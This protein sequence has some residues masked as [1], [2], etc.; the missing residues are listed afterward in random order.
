MMNKFIEIA[1]VRERLDFAA[2]FEAVIIGLHEIRYDA[3][4]AWIKTI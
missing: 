1:S 2:I 4:R 3:L